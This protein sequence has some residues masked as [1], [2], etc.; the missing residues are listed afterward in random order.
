LAGAAVYTST[1]YLVASTTQPAVV[2]TTVYV[3]GAGAASANNG[4]YCSTLTVK[5]LGVSTTRAG[6]CGTILVVNS[7]VAASPK[8]FFLFSQLCFVLG[9][10]FL[11]SR[12]R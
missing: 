7:G 1:V 9:F 8:V 5:G 3:A 2:Y 11:V 10:V 12:A 4:Q 6:N